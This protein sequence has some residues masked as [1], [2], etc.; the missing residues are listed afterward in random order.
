MIR[1]ILQI[2]RGSRHA[3]ASIGTDDAAILP[4]DCSMFR[5]RLSSR[6]DAGKRQRRDQVGLYHKRPIAFR[7]TSW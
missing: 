1:T 2:G 5:P 3:R 4:V 7:V 6:Y